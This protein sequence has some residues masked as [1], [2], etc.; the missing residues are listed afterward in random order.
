MVRSPITLSEEPGAKTGQRRQGGNKY[1]T[2]RLG[3]EEYGIEILQVREI[4]GLLEVTAVP[5]TPNFVKGVIN[6]RDHVI[7]ITDL[8]LK[9]G[10]PAAARS[11][12]NCIIVVDVGTVEMGIMVDSVSEVL[13]IS[14]GDVQATPG[15]GEDVEAEIF[16]GMGK[17]GSRVILLLDIKRV[18][19]GEQLAAL[20]A[21]QKKA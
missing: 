19:T 8:R 12:Q 5:C 20:Q 21:L 15:F 11:S 6:L 4:M 9:F 17:V 16:L 13:Y 2:F 10:M 14:A 7:P 3:S 18:L 1:L